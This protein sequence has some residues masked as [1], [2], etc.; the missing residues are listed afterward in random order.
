MRW[1]CCSVASGVALCACA[2]S[3]LKPCIC[4]VRARACCCLFSP[5]PAAARL[6][7]RR[8]FCL[9][10]FY[11]HS[12]TGDAA[13]GADSCR[14]DPSHLWSMHLWFMHASAA[15]RLNAL[16]SAPPNPSAARLS[17][18]C[19]PNTVPAARPTAL[20]RVPRVCSGLFTARV[21]FSLCVCSSSASVA[22]LPLYVPPLFSTPAQDFSP[23]ITTCVFCL[24]ARPLVYM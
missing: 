11:G 15:S 22:R 14:V 7:G 2:A 19:R 23:N 8:C 6:P 10:V 1:L 12:S 3:C 24:P 5:L 21:F 4:V 9:R 18:L 13:R 20:L 17:L 16:L